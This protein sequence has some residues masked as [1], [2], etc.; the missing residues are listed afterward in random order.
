VESKSNPT[1]HS[2]EQDLVSQIP[3]PPDWL[4]KAMSVPREEG[5]V[6]VDGCQ[7]R[8]YRWGDKSKPGVL[9]T[10]GFLA[11]S[12]C[13]AFIAP[14]L[15]KDFH[16]VAFD[17]SGMGESGSHAEYLVETRIREMVGVAEL[18]GLFDGGRK[19]AIVAHSF[20][21]MIATALSF[22]H[23]DKFAGMVICDLMI[24]RP[25]VLAAN[26]KKFGPPGAHRANKPQKVYPDYESAKQRFVLS[27]PQAVNEPAL[28]DY[29][30]Y[31]SLKQVPQGWSWKFDPSVFRRGDGM[32]KR[33]QDVGRQVALA[34]LRKVIVYGRDSMLFPPDSVDY[35]N[36]LST[37]LNTDRIPMIG[38]P[39]ARHHLM[40]DQPIAFANVLESVL[41]LWT[42]E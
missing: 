31:H 34:P 19:P 35:M 14:F 42:I 39:E 23:A 20:G 1:T 15:A 30:A 5:F 32:E 28:F 9:M 29:M 17:M 37:E 13:F 12:R 36:E 27:P 25:E 18:T 40:L 33:W 8:Y 4:R 41:K 24:L 21:G 38:I 10:H 7:I 2:G 11:H 26:S 16:L 22:E 6:D 3:N